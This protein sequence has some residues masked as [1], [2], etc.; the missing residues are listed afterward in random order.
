MTSLHPG[1]QLLTAPQPARRPLFVS[2]ALA[3]LLA[4]SGPLI[5]CL[6]VGVVGWFVTDAGAHGQP[7]DGLRVGAWAWL[8]AHGS[9]LG[10]GAITVTVL[11][12][13]L[14]W[15]CAHVTWRAARRLGETI[16]GFGPDAGGVHNGE[17]DLT[18]PAAASAFLS[19]YAGVVV[20]V[21]RLAGAPA[22]ASAGR[23]L[24]GVLLMAAVLGGTAIA[25]GSG[26]AAI[27]LAGVPVG[28]RAAVA[29]GVRLAIHVLV[30][31]ALV[32]VAAMLWHLDDAATMASGIRADTGDLVLYWSAH[33]LLLPQAVLWTVAFLLGPGFAVGAGTLVSPASV[34]LGPLPAVPWLAAL[35]A[36]GLGSGRTQA[37]L[38]L[39]VVVAVLTAARGH[40]RYP[41]ASL[42]E[43]AARAVGAGIVSALSLG[44]LTWLA[45]GVA[46]PGRMREVGASAIDVTVHGI[47]LLGL[48][49][50]LGGMAMTWWWRR[51]VDPSADQA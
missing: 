35:P 50:L 32:F 4:A 20:V 1:H 28:V 12:L 7:S 33:A 11:P 42:S 45:G 19:A 39:P 37:L 24:V 30:V 27:W 43:G 40:L 3:G 26:R 38:V 25:V 6:A 21:Y 29:V 18:V 51:S 16:S 49:A 17:R 46:G 48:G 2:A 36:E 5:L 15:L 9:G 22:E 10:V 13:L 14:T 8:A 23:L 47:A 44:V 41:T 34:V 31:A